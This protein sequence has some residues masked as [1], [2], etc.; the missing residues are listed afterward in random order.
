[1]YGRLKYM[2]S[3]DIYKS[4]DWI[5]DKAFIKQDEYKEL[6]KQSIS[7][8][9]KFW[10]EQGKRLDWITPFTKVR[11]YSYDTNNLYVKWYEDG[12]LNASVNCL[13]RHVD[14]NGDKTA[15]IWEGDESS[16]SKKLPIVN[17]S[18]RCVSFQMASNH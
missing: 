12:E 11:D 4:K 5:I 9:E 1:M 17:C 2:S 7:N 18:L 15:I 3:S 16:D 10:F 6:Y 14:K 8:P 13:D